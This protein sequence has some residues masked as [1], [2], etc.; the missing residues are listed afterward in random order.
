MINYLKT[1]KSGD[2][3]ETQDAKVR[4]TVE[5]ILAD[6]SSRGDDALRDYSGKFDN[7]TPESFRLTDAEIKACYDEVSD[8]VKDDIAFAQTQIR[9]FGQQQRAAIQDIEVET[10]PGVVLG[11]KN[12]PV[13]NTS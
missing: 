12:I 3:V 5:D 6:I 10:L 13:N 9:N 2:E 7:W 11:H 1:G 8:Q 4:K